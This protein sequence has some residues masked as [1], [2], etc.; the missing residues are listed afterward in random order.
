MSP[1][2]STTTTTTAALITEQP[3]SGFKTIEGKLNYLGN[4]IEPPFVNLKA[5]KTGEPADNIVLEA[6][7]VPILD[8]SASTKKQRDAAGYTVEQSGF[9]I[10]QGWGLDSTAQPWA[11]AKWDEPGWIE[12]EYY[13]DVDALLK[14]HVG[15]TSTFIF[16]HTIRKRRPADEQHL[17]DTPDSRQPVGQVHSDQT[18]WAGENRVQKHLGQ[19][20]LDRVLAGKTRAQIINVWRPLR[21]LALDHPLAFGDSRTVKPEDWQVNELRYETWNGQTYLIRYNPSHKWYYYR[22]L[23]TDK[24]ILLKCY[25][26]TSDVRTPHTAFSDPTVPLDTEPRWSIEV[27]AIVLTDLEQ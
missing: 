10:L 7:T 19:E 18:R 22:G 27:R 16:D 12:N 11:E 6:H 15:A 5:H 8:L 2:A 25:D 17:P 9:E 21:G 20:V 1:T 26:S 3:G 24:A 14:K 4:Q 13:K 23:P